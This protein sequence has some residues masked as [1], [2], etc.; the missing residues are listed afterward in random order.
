MKITDVE[1]LVLRQPEIQY[2]SDSTQDASI[3]RVHTDGGVTGVGDTDSAPMAVKAC[4]EMPSSHYFCRGLREILIGEDPL[5]IE[6]C[7]DKMYRFSI[8]YGRRGVA[9][10]AMGALDLALWDIKGK[11]EGK[12]IWALW[13]GQRQ[14]RI[15]AYASVLMPDTPDEAAR[16]AARW[17]ERG[18]TA[19]KMGWGGFRLGLPTAVELV[20]AA[21]RAIGDGI[22]LL[23]DVGF[24]ERRTGAQAIAW[25]RRLEEFRPFWIEE[26]LPP[27]DLDG[28]RE[29][30]DA[31][32]TRIATGENNA[33]VQEFQDLLDRARVDVVQPDVT[34]CGGLTVARRIGL[35]AHARGRPCVPHAW[36]NGIVVAASLHLNA[37]LPNSLLQ[38]FCQAE[39]P[40]NRDL[41]REAFPAPGGYLDV[42]DRP[43]L[44]VTLNEEI[45][46]R[47]RVA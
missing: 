10:H 29:L 14:T 25:V 7:W 27:D 28:Y 21:R 44:G 37:V 42:P 33:T 24:V 23:I 47:H 36:R 34:R 16:L 35:L 38:E 39:T 8:W 41:V 46:H 15:R 20:R 32:E 4:I 40:L 3:V 17:A 11:V 30:A 22:D 5:D 2:I 13:G 1:V 45:V 12:P 31:V 43:G 6:G 19:I 26:I 9:L 18:F